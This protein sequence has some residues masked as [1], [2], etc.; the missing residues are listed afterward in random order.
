M[1]THDQQLRAARHATGASFCLPFSTS[2]E[3][4][5]TSFAKFNIGMGFVSLFGPVA[6]L[7]GQTYLTRL[8][9]K[10]CCFVHLDLAVLT[11]RLIGWIFM[12]HQPSLFLDFQAAVASFSWRPP[13]HRRRRRRLSRRRWS[14]RRRRQPRRQNLSLKVSWLSFARSLKH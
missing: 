10:I 14:C 1:W 7:W 13:R 9:P 2:K 3:S 11:S 6:V 12:S 8:V 5:V 4:I